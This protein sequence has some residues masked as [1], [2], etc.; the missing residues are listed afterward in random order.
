MSTPQKILITGFDAAVTEASVRSWLERFGLVARVDIIR[1]GDT[2]APVTLVEMD[3][4]DGAAE[5]LV[6]RLNNY[7]HDGAIVNAWLLHH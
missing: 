4:G 2:A 3:I 5:Y 1:K 7:W 6:A